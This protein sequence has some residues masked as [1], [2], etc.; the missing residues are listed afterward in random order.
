VPHLAAPHHPFRVGVV[1]TNLGTGKVVHRREVFWSQQLMTIPAGEH[2]APG[3]EQNFTASGCIAAQPA[4]C[5]GAYWFRL[6][7]PPAWWD[8]TRLPGGRYRLR[9]RAWD[10]AGNLAIHDAEATIVNP[11]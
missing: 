5:R 7:R 2:Y 1:I 9:V 6:F 10:A 4:T 8:T 11:L 3:T